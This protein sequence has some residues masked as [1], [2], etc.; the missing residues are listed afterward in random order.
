M[1]EKYEKIK[2]DDL[3]LGQVV[4]D[5]R[6]IGIIIGFEN[7]WKEEWITV[8]WIIGGFYRRTFNYRKENVL[9]YDSFSRFKVLK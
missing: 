7:R 9:N 2:E 1:N 6:D 8:K 5:D 3:F 4:F